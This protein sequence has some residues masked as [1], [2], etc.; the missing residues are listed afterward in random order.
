MRNKTQKRKVGGA[1][2]INFAFTYL[3]LDTATI[4][5]L[6]G[7]NKYVKSRSKKC[8]CISSEVAN[9]ACHEG[10]TDPS[11][12]IKGNQSLIISVKYDTLSA[13]YNNIQILEN[14][15]IQKGILGHC[16][17]E[18]KP[19]SGNNVVAIYDV[20]LHQHEREGYGSVLFNIFLTAISVQYGSVARI[21]W[22][23]IKLDNPNFNKILHL[24]TSFGFSSPII[25]RVDPWSTVYP[26]Y[27][28]SLDKLI[29]KYIPKD[30]DIHDVYN[31]GIEMKMQ[32][33]SLLKN[34]NYV[35]SMTF[36]FDKSAILNLRLFPYIDPKGIS[37]IQM[38]D[39]QR[40][41][42]GSFLIYSTQLLA[43]N[44]IVYTLSN[45]SNI[46]KTGIDFLIGERERV[47]LNPDSYTFHTHPI[48]VYVNNKVLIGSPSG[49]DYLVTI[50]YI[51]NNDTRFHI[52]SSIEGIYIMSLKPEEVIKLG[53]PGQRE[54]LVEY[55]KSNADHIT[56]NLDFPFDRRR[57]DWNSSNTLDE[58]AVMK[59]VET[60]LK[61]IDPLGP[62]KIQFIPWKE[63]TK[64]K[65]IKIYY[66]TTYL[67]SFADTKNSGHF[68]DIYGANVVSRVP[69]FFLRNTTNIKAISPK[70]MRENNS[71][72]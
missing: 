35:S 56:H 69:G 19:H 18:M 62:L 48:A 25:T 29:N 63:L 58:D 54:R 71:N 6:P 28:L 50:N 68:K 2:K 21:L 37:P 24:Y 39:L 33:V 47:A 55:V 22:L 57:F 10:D 43:D 32:L 26:F 7:F 65:T 12:I 1:A 40:E 66:P 8:D 61:W 34:P 38:K 64:D 20:C 44:S 45:K 52:V 46:D 3:R 53:E 41:Y 70:L 17:I 72:I 11:L 27:M 49:P 9:S 30:S 14:P 15:V 16:I 31:K 5:R 4:Q 67:N 36:K 59:C 60:Y 51:L 42:S 23:G 13:I